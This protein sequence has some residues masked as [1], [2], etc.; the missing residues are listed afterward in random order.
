[1]EAASQ[2]NRDPAE[3]GPRRMARDDAS[4][5]FEDTSSLTPLLRRF[6]PFYCALAAAVTFGYALYDSFQVDGDA[7]A[8][9]DIGDNLRAHAWAGM[10][11][12]YWH[13]LYPALLA[14][15]HALCHATL[16]T[17]LRAYYFVNYGIFLLGMAAVVAFTDAVVQLRSALSVDRS[18]LKTGAEPGRATNNGERTTNNF[19]LDRYALRYLGVALVAIA[20]QRELSLG[21]VRPDAL[22]QA[23]LLLALAALLRHLATGRVRYAAWMG[24]ALGCAYLTKSFAFVLAFLAIAVLAGFRWIWLKHRPAQIAAG[25]LTALACFAVVAG[26]YVAAL[27]HARGRFD[28]GDSG[29]LNYAWYVGG[30]EKMHLEPYMTAQFGSAEVK[31]KHPEKELLHSPQI[32]SYAEL[33][34]GTY[35]DWWDTTYWNEQVK[36]HFALR[37]EI[38]RSARN[39]V[40]VVRYLFNHPE[41][42]ILLA[43][44][45]G[46]GARMKL[47]WKPTSQNRDM[48]RPAFWLPSLLLGVLIWGIYATVNT[49]ERYVTIAYLAI[50]L[51]L[52]AALRLPSRDEAAARLR[53]V[54]PALVVLLALLAAG[55]SLRTVLEDRRQ[56]SIRGYAAGWHSEKMEGAAAALE[57]MGVRP[58]DTVACAGFVACLDDPYWARLAGVRVLTEIYDPDLPVGDFLAALPNREQAIAVVRGQG[59][60]VLVGDFD[61]ERVSD[62]DP[63]FRQW[64]RLDGTSFYALRLTVGR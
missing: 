47:T 41:A 8:Y 26:P 43:L 17:E 62:A 61:G 52:F 32:F 50:I 18:S 42:L 29:A 3:T 25:A 28:F 48:G 55:E 44:L 10:V 24:V 63:F 20:S 21:K 7:V 64:Q 51:T 35:P 4:S 19:L 36:P 49:E 11:N 12:G 2:G 9:M 27:S 13:P 33:Q 56:L 23:L 6:F 1:M 31:L 40:L 46:L 54:A 5:L 60:K 16:A 15:G 34:Y 38:S 57:A 14:L 30:T 22:L 59:A 53:P 45:L 58:G 39:G 37:G